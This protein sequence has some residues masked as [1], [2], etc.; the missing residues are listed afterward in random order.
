LP[1]PDPQVGERWLTAGL[2]AGEKQA[3]VTITEANDEDVCVDCL[4]D[5]GTERLLPRQ[6][7]VRRVAE[8]P[9]PGEEN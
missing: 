5:N 2:F 6:S 3:L 4:Y 8:A 9:K 7:M 1:L